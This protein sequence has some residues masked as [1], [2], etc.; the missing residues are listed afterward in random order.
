MTIKEI[1]IFSICRLGEYFQSGDQEKIK[2]KFS[3]HGITIQD[4]K[5]YKK[6]LETAFSRLQQI[7]SALKQIQELQDEIEPKYSYKPLSQEKER[8]IQQKIENICTKNNLYSQEIESIQQQFDLITKTQAIIKQLHP[9]HAAERIHKANILFK[10]EYD[11]QPTL[12]QL[13]ASLNTKSVSFKEDIELSL[14][15]ITDHS[16]N[17]EETSSKDQKLASNRPTTSLTE[18]ILSKNRRKAHF[19]EKIEKEACIQLEEQWIKKLETSNPEDVPAILDLLTSVREREMELSEH[20]KS[21]VLQLASNN[22]SKLSEIPIKEFTEQ[23]LNTQL[24]ESIKKI[25]KGKKVTLL[26]EIQKELLKRI[27]HLTDTKEREDYV[28]LLQVIHTLAD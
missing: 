19:S 28:K 14:P 17:H 3:Q 4:E 21:N 18:R 11:L 2:K 5:T 24:K 6:I 25:P 26:K 16:S 9:N 7:T 1:K 20:L 8:S 13:L 27:D 23:L 12:E 22:P 10:N 15:A